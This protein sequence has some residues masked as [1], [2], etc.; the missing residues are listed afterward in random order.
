MEGTSLK[1]TPGHAGRTSS[2]KNRFCQ[3]AALQPATEEQNKA[4]PSVQRSQ[5]SP[6]EPHAPQQRPLSAR[7]QQTVS[8]RRLD[9]GL[10]GVACRR[11]AGVCQTALGGMLVALLGPGT[12]SCRGYACAWEHR[13]SQKK[14][15]LALPTAPSSFS[16]WLRHRL[17]KANFQGAG[18]KLSPRDTRSNR[19]QP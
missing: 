1:L 7:R 19:W 11:R 10:R 12:R 18:T 3:G 15:A 2:Q 9:R 6:W 5:S 4:T 17:C 8:T 16:G 13:R 14:N